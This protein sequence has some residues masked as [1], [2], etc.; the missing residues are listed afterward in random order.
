MGISVLPGDEAGETRV[1]WLG[2]ACHLSFAHS[3]AWGALGT[4]GREGVL[5]VF[6]RGH[7]AS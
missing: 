3:E 7:S 6:W 1:R 4:L 2:T 5:T